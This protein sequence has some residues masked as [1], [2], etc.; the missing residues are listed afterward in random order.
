MRTKKN[1]TAP[2]PELRSG[3]TEVPGQLAQ[4]TSPLSNVAK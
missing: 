4:I 3:S 2:H 1:G